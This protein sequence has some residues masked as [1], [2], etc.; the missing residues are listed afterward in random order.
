MYCGKPVHSGVTPSFYWHFVNVI[1][2]PVSVQN[3]GKIRQGKIA[4]TSHLNYDILLF[5]DLK[6]DEHLQ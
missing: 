5:H 1:A 3:S 2:Y 4:G 6:V